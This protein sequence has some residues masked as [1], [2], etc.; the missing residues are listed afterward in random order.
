VRG[1]IVHVVKKTGSGLF[2]KDNNTH[3]L[4]ASPLIS[5]SSTGLSV[6]ASSIHL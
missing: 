1:C 4:T 6:L 5:K 2:W 3:C